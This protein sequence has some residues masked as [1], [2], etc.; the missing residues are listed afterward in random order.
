[1]SGRRRQTLS[2]TLF[3]FLA[4]LVCTLGTLILL[5]ALVAQNTSDAAQQ[6]AETAAEPPP[7]D[8]GQ[9]TVGDVELLVEEEEFRLGELVSFRDAQTGDLEDR[10]D[11]LAHVEDHMRRIRERLKQISQAMEQAMSQDPMPAATAAEVKDLK[12]QLVKEQLVVKKLR[13][14]IETAKPRF[15]IVPHQGPN[16]TDRR[17]IYLECTAKGVTIWPEGVTITRNQLEQSSSTANP[18]DD[19]LRAARYHAMQQYGD[20]IP[21]YPM[22]LVRPGGVDSYYAARAA[23]MD[24][25][26]QFGYELVPADVNLAYPNSDPVM[27]Q[28]MEYAINQAL[29][30]MTKQSIVRSIRGSG[31]R[32]PE[33]RY[34]DGPVGNGGNFQRGTGAGGSV[35]ATEG[36]MPPSSADE[37]PSPTK[38]PRLSVS[39]M[40]RQGRQSGYRDHRMFP[41]RTYGGGGSGNPTPLTPEAAKQRLERQLQESA[42][43]LAESEANDNQ[44]NQAATTAVGQIAGASDA[45]GSH[46]DTAGMQLPSS[47][48]EQ[49]ASAVL[50]QGNADSG[51]RQRVI[52]KASRQTQDNPGGIGPLA[53]ASVGMQAMNQPKVSERMKANVPTDGQSDAENQNPA[54]SPSNS[55]QNP[56]RMVQRRGADWAL[57]SSV[58]LGRGNEIVRSVRL[59]IYP[60]RF[61]L[62]PDAVSRRGETFAV[63]PDGVNQAT[64]ELATS[65]RDRIERWGAAAPGARWSPQLKVD[66]MPGA[67][68]QYE[69]WSRLMIGSG[70][71]IQRVGGDQGDGY[72]HAE[73]NPQGDFK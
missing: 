48:D 26:D 53:G 68:Q 14:E 23:M 54:S 60:D 2:P 52:G 58:A 36:Q 1:M 63:G 69:Q 32:H 42:S 40:D 31:S 44:L 57:P 25:D 50:A 45:D 27:R 38:V 29:D 7:H 24:W 71:P 47:G 20:T 17:P 67:E 6:I 62:L 64:L 19:A 28:R 12:E 43:L 5:L 9:L 4:V 15:V 34:H 61:V 37:S 51:G 21:P 35:A 65:V 70:L 10:R 18:L 49:S 13:E 8:P 16:G 73:T 55:S 72:R 41:T 30:R 56:R 66:V 59:E 39:Q 22:L 46:R 33:G 11:Q 3:P